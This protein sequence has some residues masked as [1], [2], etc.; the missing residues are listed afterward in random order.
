MNSSENTLEFVTCGPA[1]TLEL[2]RKIGGAFKGGEILA[3]TG[4]L[5][6][7]KTHLIKGIAAGMGL[8]RHEPVNS[9]TFVIVH[10]Y[11][12]VEG[13]SLYHIDAYRL[14][15]SADL[16]RLGFDEM[17]GPDC[18]VA[19]EWAD[20]VRTLLTALGVIWVALDHIDR[21]RRRITISPVCDRLRRA[22]RS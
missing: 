13:P 8:A 12:A 6:S 15:T 22:V 7:G 5:G 19:I 3:L 10:E 21:D 1:E 11:A 4:P 20:K 9:P 16:E 14:N 18:V 2:G 17:C